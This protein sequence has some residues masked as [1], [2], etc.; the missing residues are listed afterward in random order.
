MLSDARL[1]IF[2]GQFVDVPRLDGNYRIRNNCA[3]G[4]TR[5]D[6]TIVFIQENIPGENNLVELAKEWDPTLH[7]N[8]VHIVNHKDTNH[9][10]FFFP[11]F[12]D[13]HIHA[14]QYPN[15]GLFGKTTLLDWLN[16]YTFPLENR[17]SDVKIAELV[18]TKV[19]ER[20]LAHG[21]TTAAYY[22]TIHLES[23]KLMARLCSALNQRAYIGKVCMNQN[24][25]DY[26]IEPSVEES[27]QSTEHLIEYISQLND[28]K[29]V[30]VVTPRFAPSCNDDLLTKL[31]ELGRN[32][33]L[34]IQT[35][36][37]ENINEINWVK[38]LFPKSYNY[39]DVYDSHGLLYEK[40]IL[41]H[42]IHLDDDE[43]STIKTNESGIS[44]CPISNSCLASGE[45]PTRKILN[46]GIK[47][48]LG[49]DI[50]AGYSPSILEVARHAHMV[51]RHLSKHENDPLAK[52]SIVECLYLATM[53]GAHVMD[54]Q[55][56]IGSFE[57]GKKFDVQL[58]DLAA[59]GSPIDLFP[60]EKEHDILDKWFFQGDDRNVANIW[61]NGLECGQ[62]TKC[63]L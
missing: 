40:T 5:Y 44:H 4:V 38:E 36:L 22:T 2:C 10:K 18:Y 1:I 14:S 46:Y 8:E 31:G 54:L 16:E 28:D 6:G 25:P 9:H 39:T 52:L 63:L 49:T 11:G 33:N 32:N 29:I 59:K 51:S 26:Y 58:I 13:T 3:I 19:I 42:C 7:T 48:G 23:S 41:A 17:L 20:T 53:G 34:P 62:S 35:H 30:P 37:S 21:T 24:A 45:C 57:V 47:V 27:V 15:S 61:V 50:S 12:I 56:Q 43:L 55:K 60:W